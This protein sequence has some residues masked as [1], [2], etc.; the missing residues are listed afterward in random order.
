M[1]C[2]MYGM[3]NRGIQYMF[4]STGSTLSIGCVLYV[5]TEHNITDIIGR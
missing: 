4:L 5:D 3:D 2:C 1:N